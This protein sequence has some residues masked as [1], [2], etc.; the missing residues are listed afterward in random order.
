MG[1]AGRQDA[2]LA[3]AG[4]CQHEHRPL[5][6]L[7]CLALLRVEPLEIAGAAH[8]GRAC[9][10]GKPSGPRHMHGRGGR[11]VTGEFEGI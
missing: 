4:T 1:D 3:G 6:R 5:D 8:G 2:G 7:D 10:C 11:L 9:P